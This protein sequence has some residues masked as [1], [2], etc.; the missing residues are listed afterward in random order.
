MKLVFILLEGDDKSSDATVD[1]LMK[2][3]RLICKITFLSF[4]VQ[5]VSPIKPFQ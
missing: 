1:Y 3:E 2:H 5:I 4:I